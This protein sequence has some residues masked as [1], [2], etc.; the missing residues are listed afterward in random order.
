M[1]IQRTAG[2]LYI[3]YR[4]KT[5]TDADGNTVLVPDQSNPH[6]VRVAVTQPDT[7]AVDT[8]GA[9]VGIETRHVNA[10]ANLAGV[11]MGSVV[12]D[13]AGEWW[14]IDVRPRPHHA[15]MRALRHDR[16]VLSYRP[17]GSPF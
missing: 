2:P 14:D 9:Q 17:T 7:D 10:P 1:P 3:F 4:T 11:G 12:M 16:Y 6:R 13:E 5:V 8:P 15:L